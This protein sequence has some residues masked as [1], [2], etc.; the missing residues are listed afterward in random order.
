MCTVVV[1]TAQMEA[2][3]RGMQVDNLLIYKQLQMLQM[4]HKD[5]VV[6]TALQLLAFCSEIATQSQKTKKREKRE[7]KKEIQSL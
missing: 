2:A 5:V 3:G 1:P 4:T 6:I 7:E